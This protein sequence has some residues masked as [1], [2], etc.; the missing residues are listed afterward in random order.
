MALWPGH[1]Q[2]CPP[3]PACDDLVVVAALVVVAVSTP[4]RP[5]PRSTCSRAGRTTT[6][7]TR[8]RSPSPTQ[9]HDRSRPRPDRLRR[10][11]RPGRRPRPY[12]APGPFGSWDDAFP[13]NPNADLSWMPG[14][15][16]ACGSNWGGDGGTRSTPPRPRAPPP[17]TRRRRRAARRSPWRWSP[18]PR[19]WSRRPPLRTSARHG[20]L[21]AHPNN[22]WTDAPTVNNSVTLLGMTIPLRWTP[23]TTSWDFGTVAP[24]PAKGSR[25]PTSVSPVR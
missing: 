25:T 8:S 21:R 12:P 13:K 11:R 23:V 20:L 3:L 24:P 9:H 14:A 22:Y 1:G 18:P 17:T 10:R 5:A 16:D 6:T 7:R 2:A 4:D 19:P 15:V